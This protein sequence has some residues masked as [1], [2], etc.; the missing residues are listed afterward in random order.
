MELETRNTHL[1]LLKMAIDGRRHPST[2]HAEYP[3][4]A[5]PRFCRK[6][7]R[8]LLPDIGMASKSQRLGVV[9]LWLELAFAAKALR[10]M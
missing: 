10:T 5:S 2:G 7:S 3:W 4:S 1:V 9:R 6:E 8:D